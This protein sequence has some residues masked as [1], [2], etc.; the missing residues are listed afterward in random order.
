MRKVLCPASGEE[1]PAA[2]Q[3]CP[4]GNSFTFNEPPR[5]A[6]PSNSFGVNCFIDRF[7]MGLSSMFAHCFP[8]PVSVWHTAVGLT[9]TLGTPRRG[10]VG[11]KEE[12]QASTSDKTI[13]A[14]GAQAPD[15]IYA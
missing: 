13:S 1:E 9:G 4:A 11:S 12:P 2:A 5:E 7:H 10:G 6:D 14:L 3:T 15:L 8:I